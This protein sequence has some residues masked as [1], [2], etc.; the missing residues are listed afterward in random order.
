MGQKSGAS[1]PCVASC[2]VG[3]A[4]AFV[5]GIS[6]FRTEISKL[7]PPFRVKY[8]LNEMQ[9]KELE[10]GCLECGKTHTWKIGEGRAAVTEE[11]L[12]PMP[13]RVA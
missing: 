4:R 9:D 8:M 7:L 2:L 5:V 12:A 3:V 10:I 13:A 11:P 1:V 6:L